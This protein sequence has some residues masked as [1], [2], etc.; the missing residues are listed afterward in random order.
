MAT[1]IQKRESR[2]AVRFVHQ[3]C[4]TIRDYYRPE[5]EAGTVHIQACSRDCFFLRW[6]GYAVTVRVYRHRQVLL[7]MNSA[8]L[9]RHID[10]AQEITDTLLECLDADLR[11]VQPAEPQLKS[12]A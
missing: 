9:T 3:L 11:G 1:P 4:Q 2:R 5:I 12:R 7:G 6:P 10:H 8:M